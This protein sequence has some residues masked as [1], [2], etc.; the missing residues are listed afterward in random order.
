MARRANPLRT[1]T[2]TLSTTP[3]VQQYLL[4]LVSTGLYG[5]NSAEAAERL[6]AHSIE[7]LSRDGAPVI[8]ENLGSRRGRG[9]YG[10]GSSGR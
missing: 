10:R 9:P 2:I 5:K 8:V 6:L 1:V 4:R 7:R 3:Q